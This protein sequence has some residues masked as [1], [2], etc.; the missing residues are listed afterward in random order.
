MAQFYHNVIKGLLFP[1]G[2]HPA[3]R[4]GTFGVTAITE[5]S[6]NGQMA[7]VPWFS[8]QKGRDTVEMIN[9]AHVETVQYVSESDE[10]F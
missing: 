6:A 7:E 2:G 1:A 4:V 9:A 3:I 10:P 5:E 8:I